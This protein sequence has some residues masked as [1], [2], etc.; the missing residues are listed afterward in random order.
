MKIPNDNPALLWS[1]QRYERIRQRY[2]DDLVDSGVR[3][4]EVGADHNEIEVIKERL[5]VKGALFR[6][7]EA[8]ISVN[9]ISTAC[10]ACTGAPGSATFY[11]SLKCLRNCYFCFNLNQSNYEEHLK[12]DRD[13]R[14]E[15]RGLREANR[16]MT[17]LALTGGEPLL[18][19]DE[20]VAFFE[21]AHTIWPNAHLRLYTT[22]DQLTE[23]LLDLL[24][25]VGLSE[26]RFS[27]KLD[28]DSQTK[29]AAIGR[30]RMA[31]TRPLDTMVEMP[32]IPGSFKE[33]CSL[34]RTLNELGVCGINLLEFCYAWHNW[35]EF[36]RRGFKLKNPPFPIL[37]DYS[38]A[39][40]L[41]IEGSELEAL[42]LVEF[43]ID[44]GLRLGVHY[45]SLENKHR[46]QVLTQNRQIR[47]NDP[48][49][50]LDSDDF[51]WKTC[52]VY[53]KDVGV[54]LADLE[55]MPMEGV[56]KD[57]LWIPWRYDKEDDCLQFHPRLRKR[58]SGLPV[59]I[60]ISSNI[61]EERADGVV[62]RELSL[63]LVE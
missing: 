17:H 24:V 32:V 44:E 59:V 57:N 53:G 49:F 61:L 35:S 34:L 48:T 16:Q 8:S 21:K 11:Y 43:A 52:K 18:E 62:L 50:V 20:A 30:I 4:G 13:W 28:D 60:A 37:Y 9:D 27:M 25:G 31:A 10:I 42:K 1:L 7:G 39:G 14:A 23:N 41:P 33:M 19:P 51:F 55:S 63:K 58:V 2:L 47:F 29:E 26:I 3:L 12:N 5:R 22:G 54:V 56:P 6:N 36:E 38:Y 46:D 15:L 45:C 40:S